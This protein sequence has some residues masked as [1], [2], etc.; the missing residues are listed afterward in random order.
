MKLSLI[1]LIAVIGL[2]TARDWSTVPKRTITV[3]PHPHYVTAT[4]KKLTAPLTS[5]RLSF[6]FTT[7]GFPRFRAT[8][9]RHDSDSID[10]FKFRVGLCAAVEFNDGGTPGFDAGDRDNIIR[11]VNFL[12]R[13]LFWS[14]IACSS[15]PISG[16]TVHTCSTFYPATA[17]G[18]NEKVTMTITIS[19]QYV[20]EA[21]LN[22]TFI[23]DGFKWDLSFENIVYHSNSSKIAFILAIDSAA[24]RG[25]FQ[26]N[27]D[28]IDALIPEGAVSIGNGR[29]NWVKTVEAKYLNSA[30]NKNSELIAST[31]FTD[32]FNATS[33]NEDNDMQAGESRQL[34]AFTPLANDQPPNIYW[35]PTVLIDDQALDGS[36]NKFVVS[37][38][39]LVGLFAFIANFF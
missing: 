11:R 12:G 30:L 31:L 7:L 26:T 1:V 19:E 9:F 25:L 20:K 34:I 14:D 16:T 27:P 2:A 24:V 5:S 13:G 21:L 4:L 23:P 6:T 3:D 15:S 38:F 37:S 10:A 32:D 18:T 17:T 22:R 36:G 28:P 35:D 39:V 33:T 8:Y 29:L